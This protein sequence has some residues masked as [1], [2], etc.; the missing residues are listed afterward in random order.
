MRTMCILGLVIFG[1]G[2]CASAPATE[3]NR[4]WWSCSWFSALKPCPSCPDDYCAKKLP[5]VAPVT[6][7]G[8]D[9]YCCKPLPGVCPVKCCGKDDYC[10]KP[11]PVVPRCCYPPWYI[12]VPA[13]G[14]AQGPCDCQ[15]RKP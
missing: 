15:T 3:P 4:C 2:Q 11:C 7:R 10:P 6:C 1:L 5:C 14:G 8:P 13:Q 9:D 12:C